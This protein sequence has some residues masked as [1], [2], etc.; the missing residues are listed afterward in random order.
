M[1]KIDISEACG[2]CNGT[3]NSSGSDPETGELI[4]NPCTTCLGTGSLP[5]KQ[6]LDQELIDDVE[7]TKNKV[8]WLKKNV[9]ELLKHFDIVEKP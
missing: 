2:P 7:D 6:H 8:D 1:A 9:K 4:S 5:R 3:G